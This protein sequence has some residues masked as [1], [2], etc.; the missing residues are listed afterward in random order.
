MIFPYTCEAEA[1]S[2][3][4]LQA[5]KIHLPETKCCEKN[6]LIMTVIQKDEINALK[7]KKNPL[8]NNFC[9]S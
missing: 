2:T 9:K 5:G 7:N 8:L 6:M 1:A 3:I 4:R